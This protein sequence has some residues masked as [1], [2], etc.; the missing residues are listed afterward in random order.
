MSSEW[1]WHLIEDHSTTERVLDAVA[2]GLDDPGGPQ[3]VLLTAFRDYATGFV[4]ACHNQKEERHLFPLLEAHGVPREGGPLGVMLAEHEQSKALLGQL[5]GLI[6]QYVNGQASTLVELR[7]TFEQY[8]ALLK[9]HYWKETDVLYPM[10]R[11]ILSETEAD[12]VLTGLRE[13]ESKLGAD[14]RARFQALAE[15]I[16]NMMELEDLSAGLPKEVLAAVLN[17]LPVEL[18]FVDAEDTVRYFSH[19]NQ[20]KIFPRT[21]GAIGLKV[22]QCHPPHSLYKVN[23]ILADFR[24]GRR[25]VAEFWIDQGGR[26]IHIRYF[27][28]RDARGRYLGCLEVVQDITAIQALQGERRLLED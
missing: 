3:L 14:T 7:S 5:V 2:R 13:T 19:E 6:D 12:A 21:R 28:V 27:P 9:S 18:S 24:N 26:K 17:T 15:T 4:D 25:Q 23:Q 20:H 22:Q 10:A 11:R 1:S 8:A 16:V